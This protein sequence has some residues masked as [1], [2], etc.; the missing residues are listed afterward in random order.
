MNVIL[1]LFNIKNYIA[2]LHV[3][4]KP[5]SFTLMIEIHKEQIQQYNNI[6]L[7]CTLKSLPCFS[8]DTDINYILNLFHKLFAE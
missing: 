6:F 5:Q 4:Y 2:A 8:S 7:L 1:N 3:L